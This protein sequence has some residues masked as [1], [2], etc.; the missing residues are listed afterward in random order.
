MGWPRELGT[1]AGHPF[2]SRP[3]VAD[4]YGPARYWGVQRKWGASGQGLA[5]V[6]E[7]ALGPSVCLLENSLSWDKQVH[8]PLGTGPQ[9]DTP[10]LGFTGA[11]R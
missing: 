8:E 5:N 4:S 11:L 1:D 9:S 7:T 6:T 10:G 2:T 3:A